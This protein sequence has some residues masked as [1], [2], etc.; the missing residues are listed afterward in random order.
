MNKRKSK[1]PTISP[2][3]YLTKMLDKRIPYE[4]VVDKTRENRILVWVGDREIKPTHRGIRKKVVV[5]RM[6]RIREIAEKLLGVNL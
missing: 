4:I 2:Y 1:I 6:S 5:R 3:Y